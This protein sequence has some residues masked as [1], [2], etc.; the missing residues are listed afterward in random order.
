MQQV[1]AQRRFERSWARDPGLPAL[2]ARR[3]RRGPDH[4]RG[5]H[6][7][8]GRRGGAR[9][10]RAARAGALGRVGRGR[11]GLRADRRD[12]A[13]ARPARGARVVHGPGVPR[14]AAHRQGA[15]PRAG[16]G[17]RACRCR[18][19]PSSTRSSG[20]TATSRRC[21]PCSPAPDASVRLVLTPETVVVAEARR[22]LTTLSLFGYRVDGVVAN[23]VFP[24]RRR[25]RVARAVGGGAGGRARRGRAVLR[26]AA[27]LAVGVPPPPSRSGWRRSRRFAAAAYGGDDPLGAADGGGPDDRH[28]HPVG[29]RA[30]DRTT[31]CRQVRH[32]PG[33]TWRRARG[34][35]GFLPP[36][37]RAAG[38]ARAGT[39][40]RGR[41][42]RRRAAC[43]CG[44]APE[45]AAARV[46]DRRAATEPAS[47]A[48][49]EE[50]VKLLSALQDWAKESGSEY[51]GATAA[52]ADG[53]ASACT[54]S[55][56]TS[57]PAATTARYCPVCQVISARARAPAPRS[58]STSPR[59]RRRCCTPPPASSA[60]AG[61]RTDPG[62]AR[63]APV[64]KIDLDDDAVG[65]RLMGLTVGVD[66]GGTKIAGGVVDERGTI[67]A[68]AR[69]E[70]PATDTDAI[71]AD[72]RGPRRR[73][74]RPSTTIAAVGVGAAGF[75]DVTPVDGAVRPQPRLARRAAEADLERAH[76]PA[77]RDRERRQRRGLGRVH[78]RRG[79]GRRRP[80]A[81]HGRH[82]RRRR[83]R[84]RTAQLHRGAFG[85]AAEIGHLRVVPDGRLCG[86]GNRGCW[87]QYASG[88]A[89]VRDTRE[90]ARQ[91]SLIARSLL[92]RA[93]GD[94]DGISGPARS[95]RRPRTATPSPSSSWPRSASWLGEGI[96]SLTA[97]L[98]PAVVVIG[99]GVSEAGDLLLDPVRAHFEANLTGAAL[100]AR[101][102]DPAP[103]CSATR[104]A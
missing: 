10:A 96:A 5:A 34:D 47:A 45:A 49:A 59:P 52:A 56:S 33:P 85:V 37:D 9:A 70:S 44:S 7:H 13:A 53:A 93:G 75:V 25:R 3:R 82:R 64:E 81:G 18:T 95:P 12:A 4:R 60:T 71:E 83:H 31:V 91:G 101:A 104:R 86:C 92:D 66:V 24:G 68:T 62:A 74:A 99:G 8:P 65:G 26:R 14:R 42:H 43:R 17:G 90:Q 97:V 80:P 16:E 29:G 30:A 67:L 39:R 72:H 6:R 98:D 32:R 61:A 48:S 102:G 87:E 46:A 69:R 94:V 38:G 76:R 88:S 27:G 11:R 50:A 73:A 55:T 2:R 21:T 77:G 84:A 79:R 51:A 23:R 19:T 40:G 28:P 57:R 58:S 1:D 20:C 89:L 36:A 35:R 15:A 100:P 63:R 41:A 22:S 103:R 78:V 54:R